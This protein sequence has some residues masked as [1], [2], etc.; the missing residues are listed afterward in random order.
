LTISKG[1]QAITQILNVGLFG[2]INED[3]AAYAARPR[4]SATGS[5]CIT[6]HIHR[7]PLRTP[8]QA[9]S[10]HQRGDVLKAADIDHELF[11]SPPM[12]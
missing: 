6:S 3:I 2:F 8:S 7:Q 11:A 5:I 4:F 10:R 9:S 12:L 1:A